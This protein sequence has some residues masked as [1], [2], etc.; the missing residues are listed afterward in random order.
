[1]FTLE[2]LMKCNI[3]INPDA[4]DRFNIRIDKAAEGIQIGITVGEKMTC[5]EI[6]DN[7]NKLFEWGSNNM[8]DADEE[9]KVTMENFHEFDIVVDGSKSSDF[10]EIKTLRN[11]ETGE[12]RKSIIL[13]QSGLTDLE[14]VEM[15]NKDR[16]ND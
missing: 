2:D 10:W 6:V 5:Q 14:I 16:N 3:V 12:I 15:I 13:G 7:V 8:V 1:M 4:E 9:T 11:Q